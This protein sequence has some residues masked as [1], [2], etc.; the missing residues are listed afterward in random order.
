MRR[1]CI[2][3]VEIE[4]HLRCPRMIQAFQQFVCRPFQRRFVQV[5]KP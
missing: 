4:E 3:A 5:M 2:S 1:P